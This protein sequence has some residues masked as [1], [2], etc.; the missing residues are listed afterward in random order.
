[1]AHD[2]GRDSA[3]GLLAIV[4]DAPSLIWAGLG[5]F[6]HTIDRVLLLINAYLAM[7]H[8][9]KLVVIGATTTASRLLYPPPCTPD[10][11]AASATTDMQPS[12]IQSPAPLDTPLTISTEPLPK[13]PANVY[14]QFFDVNTHIVEQLRRL[15]TTE[16]AVTSSLQTLQPSKIAGALSLALSYINKVK[17]STP[18]DTH[19]RILLLSVSPDGPTQYIPIMNAIF[20]AQRQDTPIDV[21][22]LVKDASTFLPQAC[23]ITGGIYL[24]VH[25]TENLIHHLI[26]VF[27]PDPT[28]RKLLCLSSNADVD[29]RA[30]CFCHKKNVDIGYVC[31][32]CL[33]IFCSVRSECST[34]KTQFR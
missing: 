16:M 19:S 22:R 11:I 14:K 25:D 6:D 10:A 21:C 15:V 31:S 2:G 20:A 1:M 18:D 34:C 26:H 17:T 3:S 24:Q 27:L 23:H 9:N 8:H 5:S 33:S 7:H 12:S 32:I 29:F 4:L 13:K 30:S 28:T